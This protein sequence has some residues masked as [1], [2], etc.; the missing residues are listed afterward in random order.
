[1]DHLVE[2]A[3]KTWQ[4]H[5]LANYDAGRTTLAQLLS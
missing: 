1:M 5:I 2:N 3:I 4:E